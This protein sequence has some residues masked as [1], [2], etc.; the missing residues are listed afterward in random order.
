M[1]GRTL[2]K[3]DLFTLISFISVGLGWNSHR[4]RCESH[5]CSH[6]PPA[7]RYLMQP[8]YTQELSAYRFVKIFIPVK[9]NSSS[10]SHR[11]VAF[12]TPIYYP[13]KELHIGSAQTTFFL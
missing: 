13:Q 4:K 3:H 12:Q 2:K 10:V 9:K 8:R 6:S 7:N 5:L 11:Q 1:I